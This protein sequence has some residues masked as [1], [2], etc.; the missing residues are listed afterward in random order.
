MRFALQES[1][2]DGLHFLGAKEFNFNVGYICRSY[3]TNLVSQIQTLFKNAHNT[4]VIIV[5]DCHLYN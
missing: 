3:Q 2:L 4:N 5:Y 1:Y